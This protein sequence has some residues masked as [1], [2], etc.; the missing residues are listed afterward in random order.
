MHYGLGVDLKFS[1]VKITIGTTYSTA[2]GD[3]DRPIDFPDLEGNAQPQNEDPSE[4]GVTR[5]RFI[6]GLEFPIL[7]YN[8]NFK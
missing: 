5:W 6:V 2:S 3:F 7:G 4:F 8:V 1:K